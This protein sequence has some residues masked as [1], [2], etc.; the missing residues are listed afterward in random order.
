[1]CVI[2]IKPVGAALPNNDTLKTMWEHNPDGAGFMYAKDGRVYIQKGFMGLRKFKK[3]LREI[4]DLE[5]LP[6]VMHFRI[7]T[8]GGV[9]REM[10]HPFPLSD[11]HAELTAQCSTASVGIAHNGVLLTPGTKT[12]SDTYEYIKGQLFP[13]SQALPT[14]YK[15]RNAMK[16]V[17]NATIG[18]RLAILNGNG[19]IIR[20]G[21]GWITD[22]EITYSNESYKTKRT[23]YFPYS[24]GDFDPYEIDYL[25][26]NYRETLLMPLYPDNSM[27]R[28]CDGEW[29]DSDYFAIDEKHRVFY[30]DLESGIWEHLP[31]FEAFALDGSP[32][33]F[34]YEECYFETVLVG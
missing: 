26:T 32:I 28:T 20:T 25:N 7:S 4:P 16:V 23:T 14:W 12:T 33:R 8:S 13:L 5:S 29:M 1:M 15:D 19:E 31:S 30:Y 9:N 34:N 11:S 18:S 10:T 22:G 17:E 21:Y 6:L 3:A 24:Y 27:I 2:A